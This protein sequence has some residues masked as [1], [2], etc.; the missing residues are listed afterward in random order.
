M[1]NKPSSSREVQN[2]ENQNTGNL[3]ILIVKSTRILN[4]FA[5]ELFFFYFF[6]F[7]LSCFAQMNLPDFQVHELKHNSMDLQVN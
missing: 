1:S 2:P 4:L 7:E 5:P 3:V 6:D